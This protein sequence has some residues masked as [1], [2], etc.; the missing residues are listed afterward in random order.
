M[1]ALTDANDYGAGG[2]AF[3]VDKDL[4][5]TECLTAAL[6][7]RQLVGN[8]SK[9][10]GPTESRR[11]VFEKEMRAAIASSSRNGSQEYRRLPRDHVGKRAGKWE[12]SPMDWEV[13][14]GFCARNERNALFRG[15]GELDG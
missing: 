4:G 6:E 14:F 2:V 13:R 10:P 7:A 1:I 3:E 9:A 15:G 12:D 5:E 8:Y 11:S